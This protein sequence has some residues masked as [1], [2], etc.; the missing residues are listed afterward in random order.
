MSHFKAL[1][2]VFLVTATSSAYI[3]AMNEAPPEKEMSKELKE[4]AH[5]IMLFKHAMTQA[6]DQHKDGGGDVVKNQIASDVH[7]L[8][9]KAQQQVCPTIYKVSNIH[10]SV[11]NSS[12]SEFNQ[13]YKITINSKDYYIAPKFHEIILLSSVDEKITFKSQS[14]SRSPKAEYPKVTRC[15]YNIG[16]RVGF[17]LTHYHPASDQNRPG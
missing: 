8:T 7:A 5:K 16:G 14:E 4:D 3:M 9:Q 15:V 12:K 13:D 10:D 6:E 11:K 2:S 1:L 17:I